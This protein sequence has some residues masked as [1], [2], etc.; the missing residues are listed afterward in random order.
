[1]IALDLL[2][3]VLIAGC[4]LILGASVLL[5]VMACPDIFCRLRLLALGLAA[6]SLVKVEF[7]LL[8]QPPSMVWLPIATAFV[9][10]A[11]TGVAG[12]L[13]SVVRRP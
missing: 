5:T 1:V 8:G 12:L 10:A 13:W 7:D 3:W 4:G 11:G 9:L 2:R 6:L